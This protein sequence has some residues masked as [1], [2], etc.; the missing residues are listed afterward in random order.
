MHKQ[1]ILPEHAQYILSNHYELYPKNNSY[2]T[3]Y[4]KTLKEKIVYDG[5]RYYS[6]ISFPFLL[7][8]ERCVKKVIEN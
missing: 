3:L 2:Q 6:G 1:L 4:E 7:M 8:I 5:N